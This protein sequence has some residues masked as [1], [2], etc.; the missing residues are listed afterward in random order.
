MKYILIIIGLLVILFISFFLLAFLLRVP[1]CR[2]KIP[3]ES[4]REYAM[5]LFPPKD[6]Y[7]NRLEKRIDVTSTGKV[8]DFKFSIRYI[9]PYDVSIIFDEL[10]DDFWEKHKNH[11]LKLSIRIDFYKDEQLLISKIAPDD[12]IEKKHALW[13]G[14][15]HCVFNSP[16]EIP[17]DMDIICKVTILSADELLNENCTG[18]RLTISKLSEE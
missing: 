5:F 4:M 16:E 3:I 6:I 8:Q 14:Y 15:I 11:S 2:G 7:E 9:G 17:T 18:A 1:L 13:R 10:P 12:P